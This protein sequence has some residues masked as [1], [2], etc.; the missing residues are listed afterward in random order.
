MIDTAN[1]EK[2]ENSRDK[3]L[4]LILADKGRPYKKKFDGYTVKMEEEKQIT[5]TDY[6]NRENTLT[7]PE[8]SYLMVG[9]DSSCP[10]IVTKKEW[11][12]SN[13]FADEESKPYQKE[14]S[15]KKKIGLDLM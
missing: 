12:D 3:Q 1:V 7:I 10:H 13:C 2:M 5:Y 14:K 9:E 15:E 4:M 11:D 8:G 6:D